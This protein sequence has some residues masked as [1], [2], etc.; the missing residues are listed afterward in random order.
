MHST[1]EAFKVLKVVPAKL[2]GHAVTTG[3]AK[4][5]WDAFLAAPTAEPAAA[6]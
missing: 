6:R 3:A 2:A 4:L 5:A 1:P